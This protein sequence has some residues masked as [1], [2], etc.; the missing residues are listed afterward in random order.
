MASSMAGFAEGGFT[1]PGGKYEPAGIVHRGEFVMPQDAVNRLGVP[2]L[3]ALSKG[4]SPASGAGGGKM[5]VAV[6]DDRSK[7]REY[8]ES[9]D[10]KSVIL[11]IYGQNKHLFL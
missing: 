10:G 8:L 1:G 9:Q 11:D 7:M 5:N 4:A 3:D 2:M 6:F